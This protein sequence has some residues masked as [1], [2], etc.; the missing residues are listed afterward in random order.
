LAR[1]Y[2]QRGIVRYDAR[3]VA[4]A[5]SD[6][7][8]AIGLLQQLA[9]KPAQAAVTR[10]TPEPSQE[11]ARAYKNLANITRRNDPP[12]ALE[13]YRKLLVWLRH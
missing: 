4:G 10:T 2:S 13:F 9:G 6:L 5:E 7:R 12:R 1:T 8:N 3:N 11:L